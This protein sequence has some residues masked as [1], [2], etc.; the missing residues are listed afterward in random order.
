M[1]PR[2]VTAYC[3]PPQRHS[4]TFLDH[5]HF[6]ARYSPGVFILAPC[7][8]FLECILAFYS[9]YFL[10][11]CVCIVLFLYIESLLARCHSRL[12]VDIENGRIVQG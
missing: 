2:H 1:G 9:F 8:S 6:R 10:F 3:L 7:I 4:T 12:L 11:L 5:Q